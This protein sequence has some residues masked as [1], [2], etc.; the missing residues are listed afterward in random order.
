MVNELNPLDANAKQESA[1][2]IT[3]TLTNSED[4]FST[5]IQNYFKNINTEGGIVEGTV[6]DF[7]NGHAIVDVGLKSEG[8]VDDKELSLDGLKK[9][10]KVG[11]QISV[12]IESLE[13]LDGRINLSRE[14]VLQENSWS[15]VKEKFKAE[16]DVEGEIIGRVKGGFIVDINH[17]TAFLPG[18]QVDVRPVKDVSHLVGIKQPFKVLKMDELRGNVVVSRRAILETGHQKAVNTILDS[19]EAGQIMDG[20]VKNITN[21]GAFID[22]GTIDGLVHIADIS[23]SRISHP[24]EKLS[25]GQKVQVKVIKYDSVKRQVSL[26]IKQLENDPWSKISEG[27][28]KSSKI[29]ATVSSV[30]DYGVFVEITKGIEGLVHISEI[31]WSKS[32]RE[33]MKEIKPGQ[34]VDVVI[35]EIDRDKHRI[36]LSMKR[37]EV[38][39]WNDFTTAHKVDDIVTGK[40]MAKFEYNM[41]VEIS[42]KVEGLLYYN[43]LSWSNDGKKLSENYKEGDQVEVK[44]IELLPEKEKLILGVKQL[45]DNPFNKI[46][47]F[48]DEENRVTCVVS[49]IKF[50]GIEVLIGDSIPSF[51]KKYELAK[52]KFDQ[53]TDRFAE[54]EKIDAK[55]IK[56]DQDTQSVI[57]SI[58]AL[59]IQDEK[60]AIK[61]YGSATSGASLGD[62]L[63]DAFGDL[64]QKTDNKSQDSKSSDGDKADK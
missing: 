43:N 47:D 48:I 28:D 49:K 27:M 62:I 57:L 53:R 21:Y 24:S 36:S 60:K 4:S 52:D 26:G 46:T 22:L 1:A 10:L 63:G 16:D 5:L 23:W 11:D 6:V 35:L 50:D 31:T 42:D 41:S 33:L 64:E 17:L 38:N 3:S 40:I 8:I 45:T 9:T 61:E 12:Y 13:G 20:V 14:R 29:S 30:T 25:L 54:G 18:S 37:C 2:T 58:K 55:V 32:V 19:I 51:I 15:E 7:E 56:M 34:K 44:I 59:E 39:P